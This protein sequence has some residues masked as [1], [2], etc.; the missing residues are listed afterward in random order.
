MKKLKESEKRVHKV[1]WLKPSLNKELKRI[2]KY[3]KQSESKII[4]QALQYFIEEY[5]V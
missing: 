5:G 2:A 3:S 1:Y 4:E